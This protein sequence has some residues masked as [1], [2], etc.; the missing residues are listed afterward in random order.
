[1]LQPFGWLCIKLKSLKQFPWLPKALPAQ[2]ASSGWVGNSLDSQYRSCSA[3]SGFRFPWGILWRIGAGWW[4]E[5]DPMIPSGQKSSMNLGRVS[6]TPGD[7]LGWR[8]CIGNVP[9][10]EKIFRFTAWWESS[11]IFSQRNAR[12]KMKVGYLGTGDTWIKQDDKL[13]MTLLTILLSEVIIKCYRSLFQGS[14]EFFQRR[15]VENMEIYNDRG[16]SRSHQT[17]QKI[18]KNCHFVPET[19]KESAFLCFFK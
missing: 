14:G 15:K 8:G 7:F 18:W 13:L 9:E 16:V 6:D 2:Q 12:K 19:S 3:N 10:K 1:M 11:C 4:Y 17:I 5:Y